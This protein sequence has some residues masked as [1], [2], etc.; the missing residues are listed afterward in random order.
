MADEEITQSNTRITYQNKWMIVRE[1]EIVRA[2]GSAGIYGV[3][4]KP[5]FAVIAAVDDG[6]ICLVQQYRYPV[7]G[8]F[9]EMPQGSWEQVTLDPLLL[10]KAELKEET[11]IVA[12]SM[13]HAGHLFLAYGFSTQGYDVFFA[14]ELEYGAPKLDVEEHGLIAKRFTIAELEQMIQVGAVKDASTV[15]AFGLLR[16]KGLL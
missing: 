12:R 13:I 16:L 3:V 9:W 15:A 7:Q 2:D 6:H 4:E 1:D 14:S 5:D 8:R 10:A 11:G